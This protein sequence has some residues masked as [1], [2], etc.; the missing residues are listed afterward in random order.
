MGKPLKDKKIIIYFYTGVNVGGVLEKQ[1]KPIHPGT[2][3]AYVR[4]LS[5]QEF[6][7]ANAQ[8]LSEDMIFQVNWREDLKPNSA[9]VAFVVYKGRWYDVGR[10]DTFEGYKE[11]IKLYAKT[12]SKP[13][14]SEIVAYE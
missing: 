9:G 11:D 14:D 6:I 2:L 8:Q 13:K 1:Y 7:A 4:Q 5:M 10:I 3:W 12:A